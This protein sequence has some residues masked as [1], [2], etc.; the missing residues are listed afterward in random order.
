MGPPSETLLKY[1]VELWQP[2]TEQIF[3]EED[4]RVSIE[5]VAGFFG[6]LDH[7]ERSNPIGEGHTKMEAV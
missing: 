4:A 3:S 6:L 7:W 5:N 1:T 2:R